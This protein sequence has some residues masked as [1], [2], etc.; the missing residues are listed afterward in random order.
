MNVFTRIT[1]ASAWLLMSGCSQLPKPAPAAAPVAAKP[2][3]TPVVL[4]TLGI[5]ELLE[6]RVTLCKQDKT[7]RQ[8]QL[9]LL[10]QKASRGRDD[11]TFTQ[12]EKLNGLLLSSCEPANTP[13]AL[14]EM[15]SQVYNLGDW[16]D[17]YTA[18]FDLLRSQQRSLNTLSAYSQ[19]LVRENN[20][21]RQA[22]EANKKDLNNLKGSYKETIKSIGEIEENLDSRKQKAKP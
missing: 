17:D 1:L 16:P 12:E 15:L 9:K 20:E 6:Y 22:L 21:L 7:Q 19:D 4:P 2:N 13:G 3:A 8:E 14:G 18:F 11:K 5:G 10:R